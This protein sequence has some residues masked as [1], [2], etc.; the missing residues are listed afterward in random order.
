MRCGDS[1]TPLSNWTLTIAPIGGQGKPMIGKER[2][3]EVEQLEIFVHGAGMKPK[4]AA[5]AVAE[6]LS[7][8]LA[9]A[10]VN[11]ADGGDVLVFVGEW[12][13]A[14]TEADD[15]EDGA[16]QHAPA[17]ATKTL[18]EL[19]LGRHRHVHVHRCRHVGVEVNFMSKGKRHRFSPAATVGAATAW[20]RKKFH[21]DAATAAEYVLQLC[22]STEQPRADQHLGELVTAPHCSLCFDLVKEVTPQG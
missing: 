14:L 9:R 15:V 16:D 2:A 13:E 8:V 20:A 11:I 12:D 19:E 22:K 21:L 18:G 5:A 1:K 7:N 3:M 10:G 17:D 4:V 6:I